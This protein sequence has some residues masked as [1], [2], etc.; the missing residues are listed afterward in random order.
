MSKTKELMWGI[1]WGLFIGLF[2]V[3]AEIIRG[4][5]A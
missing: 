1:G 5:I 2:W 4:A 3:A